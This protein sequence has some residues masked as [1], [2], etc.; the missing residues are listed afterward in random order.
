MVPVLWAERRIA[1]PAN[2]GGDAEALVGTDV[3]KGERLTRMR[4]QRGQT[5]EP[6]GRRTVAGL[7]DP[8]GTLWCRTLALR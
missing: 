7:G 3:H 5:I 6:H 4:E 2:D 1:K 8:H